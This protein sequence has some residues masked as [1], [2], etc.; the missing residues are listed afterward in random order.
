VIEAMKI[1]LDTYLPLEPAPTPSEPE[2]AKGLAAT[3]KE[4]S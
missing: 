2:L 3:K 4:A 1:L